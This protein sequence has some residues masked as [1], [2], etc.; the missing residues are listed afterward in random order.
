MTARDTLMN[1]MPKFFYAGRSC[2]F[3]PRDYHS[4]PNSNDRPIQNPHPHEK[5]EHDAYT[6]HLVDVERFLEEFE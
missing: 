4:E 2:S 1:R 3:A 5:Q 6:F